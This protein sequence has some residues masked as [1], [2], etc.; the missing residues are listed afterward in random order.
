MQT[1]QQESVEDWLSKL[2]MD[3]EEEDYIRRFNAAGYCTSDDVEHLREITED[4]LK[5]D[6]GVTKPGSV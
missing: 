3:E 5:V 1:Y 2:R 6:I 4:E